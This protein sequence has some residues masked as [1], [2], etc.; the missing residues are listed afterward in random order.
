M[1]VA[2]PHS[3]GNVQSLQ[4]H[5]GMRSMTWRQRVTGQHEFS[6]SYLLRHVAVLFGAVAVDCTYSHSLVV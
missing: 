5:V 6:N 1:N 4:L 3:G 2:L